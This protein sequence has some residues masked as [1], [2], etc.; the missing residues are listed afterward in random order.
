MSKLA[1]GFAAFL[2]LFAG[3]PAAQ[4]SDLFRLLRL[5]G[6]HLKWG[7]PRLGSG[8]SVKYAFATRDIHSPGA[9]N[10]GEIGPAAPILSSSRIDAKLFEAEA[11]AAFAL[12]SAAADI[13][14]VRV[15]EP[16]EADI[17]IGAQLLPRGRA[18]T[19]VFFDRKPGGGVQSLKK[20]LIC[21]N[22][23]K[24][25]KVGFDGDIE[26]YDLRY[27]IAHEIGH[28]IGLDH[29]GHSGQVMGF[30]YEE[31][32]REL[33]PGDTAG[34]TALYGKPGVPLVSVPVPATG[35]TDSMALQ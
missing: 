11:A 22:P 23:E 30:A 27:T 17:V 28:A 13:R 32:F 9:R 15:D 14:F 33:Q 18:F 19:E 3:F 20:S 16:G 31:A 35:S 21:L 4:A 8:A 12:W 25:W 7:S 34:V 26:V 1:V 29:P 5:D 10:C 6:T 24:P 2:A